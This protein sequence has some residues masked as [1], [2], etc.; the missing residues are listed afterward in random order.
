MIHQIINMKYNFEKQQYQEDAIQSVLDVFEG[1]DLHKEDSIITFKTGNFEQKGYIKSN[2]YLNLSDHNTQERILNNIH[3]IQERNNIREKNQRD[4]I[5]PIP[6]NN[7]EEK[8]KKPPNH[9]YSNILNL[10]I[11]METGTGKTYVYIRTIFELYKKFGHHKFIIVVPTIA[12][13]VGMGAAFETMKDTIIKE[14]YPDIPS[15]DIDFNIYEG[16]HDIKEFVS[17]NSLSIMVINIQTFNKKDNNNIYDEHENLGSN[18]S[19]MEYLGQVKPIVILD[20]PQKIDSQ[21]KGKASIEKLCPN[22]I[23]RYSAT[24]KHIYHEIYKLDFVQARK[25]NL[26]K[27]VHVSSIP[28]LPENEFEISLVSIKRTGKT[29]TANLTLLT[30]GNR[31]KHYKKCKENEEI[32]EINFK[33]EKIIYKK[34]DPE[35]ETVIFTNGIS[36]SKDSP[37]NHISSQTIDNHTQDKI[38]KTICAHLEK[39]KQFSDQGMNVKVLSL[40]FISN[41][42]DYLGVEKNNNKNGKLIQYFEEIFTEI[43]NDKK[44]Q[45]EISEERFKFYNERISKIHDGYF[46]KLKRAPNTTKDKIDDKDKTPYEKIIKDKK[47]LLDEQEPLRFIFAHSAINEGWDMP[48]IFQICM[49]TN[50]KSEIARIQ[51]LGRGLRIPVNSD[52]ARLKGEEYHKYNILQLITSETIEEFISGLGTEYK[53]AGFQYSEEYIK[54]HV[55]KQKTEYLD[56]NKEVLKSKAFIDLCEKIKYK[57]RYKITMSWL[58]DSLNIIKQ[59][60]EEYIKPNSNRPNIQSDTIDTNEIR[61]LNYETIITEPVLK[62]EFNTRNNNNGNKNNNII[63]KR[64]CYLYKK[65]EEKTFISRKK[66]QAI[67]DTTLKNTNLSNKEIN[68][69]CENIESQYDKLHTNNIEYRIQEN[70]FWDYNTEFKKSYNLE[71][72]ENTKYKYFPKHTKKTIYKLITLDSKNELKYI[73]EELDLLENVKVYFKIPKS[74]KIQTTSGGYTPDWAFIK[75]ESGNNIVYF[76]VETKCEKSENNL[77]QYEEI[78]IKCA[79]KFFEELNKL[80]VNQNNKVRYHIK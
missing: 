28:Y 45:K 71:I 14:I 46:A 70:N 6:Q 78:K 79:H 56:P 23:L 59:T 29:I 22:F 35:T 43:L 1:I 37:Y 63:Y 57:G 42:S 62:E 50:T 68:T 48:N 31:P 9:E 5:F 67:V 65:L 55:N 2:P 44:D 8:K 32:K 38:R 7:V 39:E 11:T 10:N 36:I 76:V 18:K 77:R 74:F 64:K 19:Y 41:V 75:T 34:T 58:D 52:G 15:H 4:S 69:I 26:V 72:L 53:N 80:N 17:S 61:I 16:T 21:N 60:I 49:L 51:Q 47:I 12:I 33:I 73:K 66:I 54:Q 20:E 13:R 27:Q 3:N 24:H 40:F 25:Q 30:Y